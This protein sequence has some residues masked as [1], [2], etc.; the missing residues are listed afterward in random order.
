MKFGRQFSRSLNACCGPRWQG[1]TVRSSLHS[2]R[3]QTLRTNCS[4]PNL[5]LGVAWNVCINDLQR[6]DEILGYR[7]ILERARG[8][9][10]LRGDSSFAFPLQ[11]TSKTLFRDGYSSPRP[12][13]NSPRTADLGL[14]V[15]SLSR[16]VVPMNEED[17][18]I[19]L[20]L[21]Y[22]FKLISI[23]FLYN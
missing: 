2:L 16:T 6:V 19:S 13:I 20:F 12:G 18:E 17:E 22:I 14:D 11:R 1:T 7:N 15:Q 9:K 8:W 10:P 21:F 5:D 23:I 4:N 3:H